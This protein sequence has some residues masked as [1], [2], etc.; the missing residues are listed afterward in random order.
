MTN[1]IKQIAKEEIKQPKKILEK[2]FQVAEFARYH[3][4][5][6]IDSAVTKNEVLE[7][8]YWGHVA[9]KL[10]SMS[11]IECFWEDG[12]K[13]LELIVI[14]ATRTEAKVKEILFRNFVEVQSKDTVAKTN[15]FTGIERDGHRVHFNPSVQWRIVRLSDNVVIKQNLPTQEA[16]LQELSDIIKALAN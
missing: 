1:E 11:K 16:A 3:F 14:F 9:S 2:K 8:S 7:P 5:A 6:V 12:S 10:K 4:H 15:A 13:Y